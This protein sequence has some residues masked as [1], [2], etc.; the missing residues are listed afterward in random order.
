M[1]VN[2][3]VPGPSVVEHIIPDSTPKFKAPVSTSVE[4]N[5]KSDLK[6]KEDEGWMQVNNKKN[7][8]TCSPSDSP[9]LPANL[10]NLK[11]SNEPA[12]IPKPPRKKIRQGQS[13]SGRSVSPV[14]S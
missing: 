9:P 3:P 5:P 10:S 8:A 4:P 6:S 7:K 12:K 14:P 2:P 11:S 1:Q 13:H